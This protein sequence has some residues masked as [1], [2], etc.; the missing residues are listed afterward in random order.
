MYFKWINATMSPLFATVDFFKDQSPNAFKNVKRMIDKRPAVD[1]HAKCNN[2]Y[3]KDGIT[4][5]M[6]SAVR[7]LM[8]KTYRMLLGATIKY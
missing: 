7:R 8:T 1:V 2:R 5:A 4:R 6:N 3:V